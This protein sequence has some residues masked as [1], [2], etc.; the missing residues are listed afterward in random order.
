VTHWIKALDGLPEDFGSNLS[1][2]L[3]VHIHL[4]YYSQGI[5]QFLMASLGTRHTSGT[6]TYIQ[7]KYPYTEIQKYKKIK[8]TP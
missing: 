4:Y 8:I 5:R 7:A 3:I 1:T 2:H 6:Q